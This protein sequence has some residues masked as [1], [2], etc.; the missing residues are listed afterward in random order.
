MFFGHYIINDYMEEEYPFP[1]K[2]IQLMICRFAASLDFVTCKNIRLVKKCF[3]KDKIILDY[4][5]YWLQNYDKPLKHIQLIQKRYSEFQKVGYFQSFLWRRVVRPPKYDW[6]NIGFYFYVYYTSIHRNMPFGHTLYFDYIKFIKTSSKYGE[7]AILIKSRRDW[8]DDVLFFVY[9]SPENN[10][11]YINNDI[12]SR[13]VFYDG[14]TNEAKYIEDKN[15]ENNEE[16]VEKRTH[17]SFND[18]ETQ[19]IDTHCEEEQKKLN[20]IGEKKKYKGVT[21]YFANLDCKKL[22][23]R[24]SICLSREY[25]LVHDAKIAFMDAR[26]R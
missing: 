1:P 3:A 11:N 19:I 17:I 8:Y 14:K 5:H 24:N 10:D 25:P 12:L 26:I 18:F 4:L 22:H 6:D 13:W 15:K 21:V 16:N 9:F 7:F 20:D 2:D 23:L